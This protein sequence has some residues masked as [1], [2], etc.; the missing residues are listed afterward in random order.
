[1]AM[2]LLGLL[3]V[4]RRGWD[5]NETIPN[6]E[7]GT[8]CL[9]YE[10]PPCLPAEWKEQI[11]H[12]LRCRAGSGLLMLLLMHW[13]HLGRL[14]NPDSAPSGSRELCELWGACDTAPTW[15]MSLGLGL[16][17]QPGVMS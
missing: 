1:M 7:A 2:A 6:W 13:L 5:R 9:P 17:L 12:F 8:R 14:G 11:S 16:S 10:F 4:S 15:A 3:E